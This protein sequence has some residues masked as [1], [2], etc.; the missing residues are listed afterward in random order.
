MSMPMKFRQN[1]SHFDSASTTVDTRP[2]PRPV[3]SLSRVS[4][5][6]L[7]MAGGKRKR[8]SSPGPGATPEA[9]STRGSKK[10][11][12][13]DARDKDVDRKVKIVYELV[14]TDKSYSRD[15]GEKSREGDAADCRFAFAGQGR[16]QGRQPPRRAFP[17]SA[18]V[19]CPPWRY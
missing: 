3:H 2:P 6:S 18:D 16:Y 11:K 12:S 7:A 4:V 1:S 17:R 19:P 5:D 15:A 9:D 14:G 10:S 13:S 8:T